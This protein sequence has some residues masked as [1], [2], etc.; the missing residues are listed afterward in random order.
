ME[1]LIELVGIPGTGKTFYLSRIQSQDIRCLDFGSALKQWLK[2]ENKK[3]D[4]P[5]PPSHYVREFIDTLNHI[6]EPIVITSHVVHYNDGKFSYDLASEEYARASNYIFIYSPPKD[7]LARRQLDNGNKN[8]IR[9]ACTLEEI[10]KH[11]KESLKIVKQLS[12]KLNSGLMILE[13]STGKEL[14]N[15]LSINKLLLRF[16]N[17]PE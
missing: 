1:N 16:K 2:K 8:K 11:Q 17:G 5:V 12:F 4:L 6:E 9:P 15:I 13:N 14:G 3:Y 7:I 10:D